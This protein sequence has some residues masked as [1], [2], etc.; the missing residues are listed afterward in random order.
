MEKALFI[1]T[2]HVSCSDPGYVAYPVHVSRYASIDA[3]FSLFG[4][5]VPP[6]NDAREEPR[7]P[8]MGGMGS[9]AVSLTGILPY[10][11]VPGAEHEAGDG[12]GA[13]TFALRPVHEGNLHLLKGVG[14]DA[15]VSQPPPAAH[16]GVLCTHEEVLGEVFRAQA[17]GQGIVREPDGRLELQQGDVVIVET[18]LRVVT[19]VNVILRYDVIALSSLLLCDVMFPYRN[20]KPVS[21]Q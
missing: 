14:F 10:R 15:S 18:P 19:R 4:T 17:D 5:L 11:I 12:V 9:A 7:V 16:Q 6:A 21:I 8:I 1:I 2:G 20:I 13:A 3:V